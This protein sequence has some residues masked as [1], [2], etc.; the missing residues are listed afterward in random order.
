MKQKLTGA[1]ACFIPGLA[2]RQ[3]HKSLP[4][5]PALYDAHNHLQDERLAS[6]RAQV[7]ESVRHE[8]VRGMVVNG[9]SEQDWPEVLDLARQHPEVLPSFGY[10]P[11]FIKERTPNWEQRLMDFVDQIPAGIGE[12]G[13]DRWIKDFNIADQELVFVA[14]LRLAAKRSLPVSIHCLQA[15]GRLLELLRE[16]PRPSCGFVLHSFGGPKEMVP[17]LAELGAYFS[18]PGYYAHDRKARQREAFK[19]V[20][21]DRLLLET[22]APDQS[23][24]PERV[25]HNLADPKTGKSI[26]HPANLAAVYD[27]AAELFEEP[28]EMLATRVEEN[29]KRLF[30]ALMT[31]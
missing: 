10:H 30:G 22:D 7:L 13:L 31:R 3:N 4:L 24:P 14:Q 2:C 6:V 23:L 1:G 18:L 25:R 17:A 12:I 9:S 27:F 26:N 16:H 28:V 19:T 8:N 11:W 21:G 5:V 20:P 29:F 15:W